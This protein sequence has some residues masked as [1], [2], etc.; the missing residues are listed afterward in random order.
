MFETVFIGLGSN[1]GD[2]KSHL[3]NA[4]ELLK[5]NS[6][7]EITQV[8]TLIETKAVSVLPQPDFL[9]GVVSIKTLLTP[10][11][12]LTLTQTIEKKCGRSAKGNYEPRTIDLDILFYGD[13]IICQ[14]ELM[15]PH[16]MAHERDFVLIPL[17]E[18][19]PE[20]IHPV[21]QE[22]IHT[23]YNRVIWGVY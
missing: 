17:N 12:L 4:I 19:S 5:E 15:I 13:Q 18:L 6:D 22:S 16:P 14:E 2:R 10:A 11:E 7:I 8:S 1:I 20:F 9:N 3:L 21:L 23:L